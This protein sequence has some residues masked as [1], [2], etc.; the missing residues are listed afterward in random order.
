M[1]LALT[2]AGATVALALWVIFAPAPAGRLDGRAL[3]AVVGCIT[4]LVL[5]HRLETDR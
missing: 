5:Q 3:A 1:R 4:F 2:V